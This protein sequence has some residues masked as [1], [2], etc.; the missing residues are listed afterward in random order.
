MMDR[1]DRRLL[2]VVGRL[3]S[4]AMA[5]AILFLA[6]VGPVQVWH[7]FVLSTISGLAR[8]FSNVMREVLTATLWSGVSLPTPLA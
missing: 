4:A 6:A 7:L 2:L 3:V 8:T 1:Y 5:A